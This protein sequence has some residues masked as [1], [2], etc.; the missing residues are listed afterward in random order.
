MLRFACHPLS[1]DDPPPDLRGAHLVGADGVP[2]RG[3]VHPANGLVCCETRDSEPLAL[4]L[5]WP[6]KDFGTV[7]LETTRLPPRD[8]S[9]HLPLELARHRLMRVSQKREEWGLFDY[10][11]MQELSAPIDQAGRLFIQA[12]QHSADPRQATRF[13]ND[14]LSLGM[15]ASEQMCRLHASVFLERRQQSGGFT[16]PFIGVSLP[17]GTA[18]VGLTR[19]LPQ[20]FDFVRLP[21]VWR[22][23]QPKEQGSRFQ[24]NDA[25]V[26]ACASAKMAVRGGPLLNFGV[27]SVPDWMYLWE[28]DY[29]AIADFAREH[30]RRTVQHYG[31]RIDSW[32]AVSGLHAD[33]AFS[34]NFEQ[35]ME[36][37][38][39]AVTLTK[40]FAPRA[41]VIVDLTQPW[42]EYYARNQRTVPPLLYA[43]MAVQSG[44]QFD[45]FGLQFLFGIDS[46]GYR[47]R[48]LLQVSALIDR[49][50]NLGRPIHITGMGVPSAAGA[51]TENTG[52]PAGGQWHGPWS[53]Q[54]Q[55]DWMVAVSEIALSKPYVES[56]CVDL[57]A[58]GLGSGIPSGGVLHEDLTPK[59][60]LASLAEV[61][62]RLQSGSSR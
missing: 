56:V 39:M 1:D 14:S 34:F 15:R 27:Q 35:I 25:W 29:E 46:G 61:R 51:A 36:L 7:Q 4:S 48:D 10:P 49:L 5:L 43:D 57:L 37:T 9:Y 2:V 45:A 41:Q 8:A 52:A 23:I 42:G 53:D 22:E 31:D 50:A 30:I 60:A 40:Q 24:V 55:A 62:R 21:L 28:N 44:I 58:D 38:R 59:P 19:R 54:T 12:L 18:K 32:I 33:Q 26:K 20:T 11:G 6:V 3:E 13:A 17:S 47:L 16:R